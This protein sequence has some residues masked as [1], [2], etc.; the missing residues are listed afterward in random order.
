MISAKNDHNFGERVITT[1]MVKGDAVL[2]VGV[3]K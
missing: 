3:T 2:H 1:E